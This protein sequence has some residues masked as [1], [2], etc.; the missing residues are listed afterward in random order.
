MLSS[1][2]I[3]HQDRII[4][5]C[6]MTVAAR[7]V[8]NL[9]IGDMDVGI[10]TFFNQLV[11]TLQAGRTP[12]RPDGVPTERLSAPPGGVKPFMSIMG[13]SAAKHG[14]ALLRAGFSVDRVIHGYGDLC[15]AITELAFEREYEISPDDFQVL[16]S[17]LDN[18]I[19]D[20]V[21]E[22]SYHHD[23]RIRDEGSA[24]LNIRLGMLAHELRNLIHTASLSL[25]AVK[26]G[27]V[28]VGG[29]TG[30]M[31]ERSLVGMRTLVDRSLADVRVRV[32]LSSVFSVL[33]PLDGFIAETQLTACLEAELRQCDFRVLPVDPALAIDVDHD[34]LLSATSNL[35]QNAFKYSKA[36]RSVS[37][38]G[39][40]SGDRVLI[41]VA[42]SCGGLP[43]RAA[44]SL[45]KPFSQ[46]G[47]DRSGLGLGLSISER[48]V[49]ANAGTLSVRNE[50][51]CGCI[52]TISLPRREWP[53]VVPS[54]VRSGAASGA[55]DE[56]P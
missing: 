4:Q 24:E 11:L 39:Y 1:F 56:T 42:D 41:E 10:Q 43:P 45:F 7:N 31:L 53:P 20:S 18:A 12:E 44:E 37:L 5:R 47:S 15:Q 26:T 21:T 36:P 28:A 46:H 6:K 55:R 14:R 35:L 19:A 16:N 33:I 40:A 49:H 22:Y 52:F 50:P 38:K 34:L 27:K 17:C 30:E 23:A 25:A 32:G 8:T 48:S 3:V 13:E 54:Q 9:N 29:A 51:G 2:L